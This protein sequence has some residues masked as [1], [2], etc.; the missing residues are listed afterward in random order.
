MKKSY[1]L[2]AVLT[3]IFF[4][5]TGISQE[6]IGGTPPSFLTSGLTENIENIDLAAPDVEQLLAEDKELDKLGNPQR[7][8]ENLPVYAGIQN[9]GTWDNLP[10]GGRI[11]RLSLSSE[12]A[13]ALNVQF[14]KFYLPEGTQLFL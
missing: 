12:N 10:N 7:I 13:L 5:N 6:S 1:F 3:F 8:A 2:I 4:V 9:S 11:W 14:D